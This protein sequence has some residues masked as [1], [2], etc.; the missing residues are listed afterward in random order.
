M[1]SWLPTCYI[2][3]DSHSLI[4]PIQK[5][6][7]RFYAVIETTI[8]TNIDTLDYISP[9]IYIKW[10]LK[11]CHYTI[12]YHKP[13]KTYSG[14]QP[15]NPY[16]D[17]S[18]CNDT[19][20]SAIITLSV[21]VN[22]RSKAIELLVLP[23]VDTVVHTRE[24]WFSMKAEWCGGTAGPLMSALCHLSLS[25]SL[26]LHY[27]CHSLFS[28]L[29]SLCSRPPLFLP[30]FLFSSVSFPRSSSLCPLSSPF[31]SS[32]ASLSPSLI[33]SPLSSALLYW[34]HVVMYVYSLRSIYR[35]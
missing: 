10:P 5:D 19:G 34:H 21:N 32:S 6:K 18:D 23:A 16:E 30:Q 14:A 20:V 2:K 3:E 4:L 17:Q 27:L 1:K 31:S 35:H 26:S 11:M 7:Y 15:R 25:F 12:S 28:F 33:F 24:N 22:G 8:D 29:S 9:K 13:W